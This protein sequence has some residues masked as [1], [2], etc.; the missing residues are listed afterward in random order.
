[1]DG[2]AIGYLP[3]F[4]FQNKFLLL[5]NKSFN[6]GFDFQQ[7]LLG[8]N[9]LNADLVHADVEAAFYKLFLHLRHALSAP[10]VGTEGKTRSRFFGESPFR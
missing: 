1:M 3:L 4:R 6:L 2:Q 8:W 7:L 5:G 9:V 10:A